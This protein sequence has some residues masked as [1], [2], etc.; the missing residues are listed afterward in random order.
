MT[1]ENAVEET[2]GTEDQEIAIAPAPVEEVTPK[3]K[4]KLVESAPTDNEPK[5]LMFMQSGA[6]WVTPSGIDFSPEHPYKPV[7]ESEVDALLRSE[8]FRQASPDEVK[9]FYT[10]G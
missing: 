2:P 9:S 6:G 7:P 3:R 8:R 1:E 4:R 5:V 10:G